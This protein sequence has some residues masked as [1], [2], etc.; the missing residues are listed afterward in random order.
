[1]SRG[2]RRSREPRWRFLTHNVRGLKSDGVRFDGYVEWA[3]KRDVFV[4]SLQETWMDGEAVMEHMADYP[5]WTL[6]RHGLKEPVCARGA[7]GVG[8]LLSP[9]ATAA[10]TEAGTQVHT[11][12]PRIISTRLRVKD[13]RGR[14]LVLYIVSAYAPLASASKVDRARYFSDLQKCYDTCA[15]NEVF[16]LG[17][18]ANAA[19]GVTRSKDRVLGRHGVAHTNVAGGETYQFLARN[20]LCSPSTFFRNATSKGLERYATWHH[21]NGGRGY[22]NDHF[23]LRQ[24]D[25]KRVRKAV[26][27]SGE[28]GASS[29][30]MP[31]LLDLAILT[32]VDKH[33]RDGKEARPR[34]DRWKFHEE[35]VTEAFAASFASRIATL[36]EEGHGL[37]AY[38][39]VANAMKSAAKDTITTTDP[40]KAGWFRHRSEKLFKVIEVRDRR[41]AEYNRGR[42]A[43]KHAALVKARRRVKETVREAINAWHEEILI[44][45]H[46]LGAKKDS[47]EQLAAAHEDGRPLSPKKAW[48][49]IRILQRGRSSTQ[50][51]VPMKLTKADGTPASSPA[52]NAAV[53]RPYLEKCFD[54]EGTFDL[55]AIQ[56]VRQRRYRG[57]LNAKPTE[58][59][60][61]AAI[62]KMNRWRSGGE[63]EIPAEYFKAILK[64]VEM[65]ETSIPYRNQLMGAIMAIFDEVWTSGSYPG[66]DAI[67]EPVEIRTTA[68]ALG[69]RNRGPLF[70]PD[71]EEWKFEYQQLNPKSGESEGRYEAYKSATNYNEVIS[72]GTAQM[73]SDGW[74]EKQCKSKLHSDIK[75]DIEHGY[76]RVFD[77][78]L[79]PEIVAELAEGADDDGI[80]YPEWLKAKLVLLPKKGDLGLPKNWRGICLLDIAS[81]ILSCVIVER[82]KA[83]MEEV[84]PEN[85]CGFR[86]WRGTIDGTFNLLMALRKRQEHNLETYVSFVDLVKAFDSVPR[87]ALFKVLRRYGMP[88]HFINIVIRL[89]A[90]AVVS[91]KLGKEEVEVKNKIGV[92]QG[93]CE[94]P[95]LFIFVMA[96]AM[97]TMEWPVPKPMF[98]TSTEN[99]HLHG[100]RADRKRGAR[101]FEL[102]ASLFADD[103]AVLFNSHEDMVKGMDYMYRHFLKFGLEIHLGRG[104]AKS[105]TEAMF[106]PKPRCDDGSTLPNF[107]CADGFISYTRIFKY[108]GSHIV[109]GLDSAEEIM[110][111]IQ[112]ASQA[113]GCLS[114]S[115]F[116]N[117]DVSKF[118]KG[119]IYVALI[120]SILLHGCETWFVREEEYELLR[121]FHK[122][123]VRTMCRVSMSQVRRHRIRTSK[124]LEEL[125]LQ[126]FEYYLE[127]RCLRWAGHVTRMDMDRTPRMLLTSWCPSSRVRGRPRMSFGHTIKKFIIKLNNKLD[128]PNAKAW[129]ATLKGSAALKEQ[130]RWTELAAKREEWRKII[131]RTDGW[132]EREKEQAEA[133]TAERR[134]KRREAARGRAPRAGSGRHA[135]AA[136]PPPGGS[137]GSTHDA[138]AARRAAREQANQQQG[139]YWN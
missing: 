4:A 52:E 42:N 124:L 19:L 116:I 35:G 68:E 128:D 11:F 130:W 102:F 87:A 138:R 94:G 85:Q 49:M 56:K 76:L 77:P 91:Y 80:C 98:C 118:L 81:K 33:T 137:G 108:L 34:V 88:D 2:S 54:R 129:D 61:V 62:K 126:P 123:C 100:E 63:A 79:S 86:P 122:S 96:A 43:K 132:R 125:A 73:V 45:C 119:R 95:I 6:L 10:W 7:Q 65:K 1:M 71:E 139:G 106:F 3:R 48:E 12:G 92:R 83:V 84:G 24:R 41:Q 13:N 37:N 28:M 50:K 110:I 127:S 58:E 120:L 112:K 31:V 69:S 121:L 78:R 60:I 136:P 39:R 9:A 107:P 30:H 75:F 72:L 117:K 104:T 47:K 44:A 40:H 67:P 64:V 8:I 114:A 18:D 15:K 20:E 97:E 22:Q 38:E 103:C 66:E 25:R 93:A 89:H 27:W 135:T 16:M 82:L 99:H 134:E 36:K 57:D 21:P 131:Q 70:K 29:D 32:S 105:K 53:L 55:A 101:S 46:S 74:L 109:P 5:G 59:E 26:R 133:A 17:T 51:L 113:F 23:F 111:R 90:D 115:T 14:P